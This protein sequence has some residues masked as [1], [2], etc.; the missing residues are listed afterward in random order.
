MSDI[1]KASRITGEY[2]LND[3]RVEKESRREKNNSDKKKSGRKNYR[4]KISEKKKELAQLEEQTEKIMEEARNEAQSIK[5]KAREEA[6]NIRQAAREEG[7][8][9]GQKEGYQAGYEAGI[10]ELEPLLAALKQADREYRDKLQQK[11][12]GLSEQAIQLSVRIARRIV[13][14]RLELEP[15]LINNIVAD[16]LQKLGNNHGQVDVRIHPEL[17]EYLDKDNLQGTVRDLPLEIKGDRG[18]ERGDCIISTDFG[19]KD[20]T[21]ENKLALLEGQLLRG[22]D[23]DG[24]PQPGEA[25]QED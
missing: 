9:E 19:G 20:G 17:I 4:E 6:E 15:E 14:S 5:E 11:L 3:V 8:K 25:E 1:I 22:A 13:N 16:M 2:K 23:G 21:L 7:Y 10:S 12:D 24:G 18:L